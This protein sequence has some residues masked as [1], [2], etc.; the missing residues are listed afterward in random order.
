M[1]AN[2]RLSDVPYVFGL[3]N[4]QS[5]QTSVPEKKENVFLKKCGVEGNAANWSR[6]MLVG[7]TAWKRGV[8]QPKEEKSK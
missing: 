8:A 5:A 4:A 6:E 2:F 7:A 1:V 3:S